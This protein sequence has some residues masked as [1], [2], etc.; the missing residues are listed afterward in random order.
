MSRQRASSWSRAHVR[1][2]APTPRPRRWPPTAAPAT[3][4]TSSGRSSTRTLP[5]CDA[6]HVGSL[7]TALE[8]GRGTFVDLVEQAWAHD[9]FVSFDPNLRTQFLGDREQAWRDVE[10]LADAVRPGQ[11]ERRGR[12]PAAPRSRPDDIAR[13]LLGG[14]RTELVVITHGA[15]GAAAYTKNAEAWVDAPA[16]DHGRHRGRRRL[17]HVRPA[18]DPG[19]RRRDRCVRRRH[20]RRR[21]VPDPADRRRGRGSRDHLFPP[22]G[23]NPPTRAELPDG[24]PG[25]SPG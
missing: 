7:G 8:P 3:R 2:A 18:G 22:A 10:S 15:S 23:A 9:V 24:W 5:R 12:P 16:V 4:S 14:D 17:V 19:R 21:G 20:A 11:A 25:G 1:P 13:S 6:L